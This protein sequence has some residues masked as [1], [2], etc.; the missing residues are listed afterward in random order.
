MTR[1]F[2]LLEFVI[3]L[4]FL[5]VMLL[6][7][8]P[9]FQS[10]METVRMQRLA[11]ELN[12]FLI[13]AKSE[14]VTRNKKLYAHFSFPQSVPAPDSQWYI[15]LT[16]NSGALGQSILYLDGSG[17]EQIAFEHNYPSQYITFDPVRGRPNGGTMLFHPKGTSINQLSVII[18]NPP[19]RIKVCGTTIGVYDYEK[20]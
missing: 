17:F 15:E 20:C 18:A 10:V 12:G 16:D 6:V 9:S 3:T 14:A 4:M 1:G 5:V 2:T 7:A 13:Q 11:S 19:G 8:V